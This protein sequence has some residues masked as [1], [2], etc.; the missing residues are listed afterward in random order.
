MPST[1]KVV[2][3]EVAVPLEQIIVKDICRFSS[4]I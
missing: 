3:E 2:A 1:N 4:V